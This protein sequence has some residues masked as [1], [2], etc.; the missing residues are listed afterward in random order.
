MANTI[1]TANSW[2]L[3]KTYEVV[4]KIPPHFF[5]WNIGEN[6]GSDKYIPLCERLY[7]NASKDVPAYYR[8]NPDTLKAI[9]LN[10]YQVWLLRE[11]AHH[12][13]CSKQEA[14]TAL[15]REANTSEQRVQQLW[16]LNT[17]KIFE[18]ITA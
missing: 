1:T 15:S 3:E 12:G 16:A 5:V 8:I 18:D 7:P 6:M 10:P 14:L 4:E 2:G 11:A 9:K 17:I 13:I